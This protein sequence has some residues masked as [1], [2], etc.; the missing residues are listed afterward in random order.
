MVIYSDVKLVRFKGLQ[1]YLQLDLRDSITDNISSEPLQ[2]TDFLSCLFCIVYWLSEDMSGNCLFGR[3]QYLGLN[4]IGCHPFLSI[5]YLVFGIWYCIL[6]EEIACLGGH[7][8]WDSIW[9]V[10]AET[11]CLFL[12]AL[13]TTGPPTTY[14]YFGPLMRL[15]FPSR[16]IRRP[17]LTLRSP[18]R[19]K[20]NPSP[21]L[22]VSLHWSQRSQFLVFA[23]F[24]RA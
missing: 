24:V 6:I 18:L 15:N 2:I 17:S 8:T 22:N 23:C 3:P 5:W 16:P 10:A 7:N 19:T 21:G 11:K 12:V 13:L 1:A 20:P 4:L 9:L 14:P